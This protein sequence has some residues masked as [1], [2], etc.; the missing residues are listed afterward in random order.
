MMI[1]A[2]LD[3]PFPPYSEDYFVTIETGPPSKHS[4]STPTFADNN[5]TETRWGPHNSGAFRTINHMGGKCCL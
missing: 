3:D 5:V 4:T 1:V 2:D